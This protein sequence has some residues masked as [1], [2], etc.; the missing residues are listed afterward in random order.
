MRVLYLHSR[1]FMRSYFGELELTTSEVQQIK[2][3][4]NWERIDVD[5]CKEYT[6]YGG[7]R[8]SIGYLIY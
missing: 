4:D 7:I 8:S 1:V 2:Q 5:Y 6:P 3:K